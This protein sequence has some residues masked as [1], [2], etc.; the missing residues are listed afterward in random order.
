MITIIISGQTFE[1]FSGKDTPGIIEIPVSYLDF[2]AN[3]TS[4]TSSPTWH[5]EKN[6]VPEDRVAMIRMPESMYD[7]FMATV[8]GNTLELPVSS[9]VRQYDNLTELY[10][11]INPKGMYLN[12]SATGREEPGT[13]SSPT[14]PVVIRTIPGTQP[15]PSLG[16]LGIVAIGCIAVYAAIGKHRR[17]SQ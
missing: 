7:R 1:R 8:S 4:S 16:G 9:Y 10:A 11:Q 12:D 2:A 6:L 13:R 14:V 3:F 5:Y 17:G 15:A